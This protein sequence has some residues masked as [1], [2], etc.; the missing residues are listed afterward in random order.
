MK[1]LF[2]HLNYPSRRTTFVFSSMKRRNVAVTADFKIL[3]IPKWTQRCYL[4]VN[5]LAGNVCFCNDPF[6][7]S[8]QTDQFGRA[9]QLGGVLGW[10]GLEQRMVRAGAQGKMIWAGAHPL[11]GEAEGAGLIEPAEEVILGGHGSS[12][13]RNLCSSSPSW[14]Y[15]KTRLD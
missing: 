11:W 12:H 4:M 1:I 5:G 10:S 8:I 7:N 6:L 2:N 14:L 13:Q 3:E 9:D 15:F